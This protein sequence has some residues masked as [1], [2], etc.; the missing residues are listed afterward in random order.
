[1]LVIMATPT[2]RE[3]SPH[4]LGG[5]TIPSAAALA[6][7]VASFRRTANHSD[8]SGLTRRLTD[9]GNDEEQ[10]QLKLLGEL[11][12]EMRRWNNG[13]LARGLRYRPIL[14]PPLG[15]DMMSNESNDNDRKTEE[16][17]EDGDASIDY[18]CAHGSHNNSQR[19]CNSNGESIEELDD[20]NEE[21]EGGTEVPGTN[22]SPMQ[23]HSRI[24]LKRQQSFDSSSCSDC[25]LSNDSFVINNSKSEESER[26]LLNVTSEL[27]NRGSDEYY[28][29]T[30]VP[31]TQQPYKRNEDCYEPKRVTP[32]ILR[33]EVGISKFQEVKDDVPIDDHSTMKRRRVQDDEP[34]HW[35]RKRQGAITPIGQT[36]SNVNDDPDMSQ[37]T[38]DVGTHDLARIDFLSNTPRRKST[39][40]PSQ[41]SS[42]LTYAI[43]TQDIK[44]IDSWIR[45]S[46]PRP[47]P[48]PPPLKQGI[49]SAETTYLYIAYDVLDQFETRALEFLHNQG[50][51]RIVLDEIREVTIPGRG[52]VPF[53]A[54][55][56]THGIVEKPIEGM[57]TCY[58]SY[59]YL[60][61]VALGALAVDA[62][63]LVES[64]DA[65]ILQDCNMYKIGRDVETH[66]R[67]KAPNI[68]TDDLTT[69]SSRRSTITLSH[70]FDG[71]VLGLL[72]DID[73]DPRAHIHETHAD[74][75]L[76]N[77][78]QLEARQITMQEI[79]SLVKCLGGK[80]CT[81][82]LTLSN[83]LLINDWSTLN[84][85]MKA[86]HSNLKRSNVSRW[87]V[88][89][90]EPGELDEFIVNG[91][92]IG[93]NNVGGVQ[94][95]ARI[96]I[97]R[98]K[99]LED[100]ICLTS[101]QCLDSYCWGILDERL[102]YCKVTCHSSYPIT[103]LIIIY[104]TKYLIKV[105]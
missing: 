9:G 93:D 105:S 72:R 4:I 12:D 47:P 62:R 38:Y 32:H 37:L 20:D 53:P 80:V 40:P 68:S 55:L 61:A 59:S 34:V 87:L 74:I 10:P 5:A 50:L 71:M 28:V 96:P 25:E 45:N 33:R 83:V 98:F 76:N 60:K 64:M 103:I 101:L 42:Q 92:L 90:Y 54:I 17:D 23:C 2:P 85:I 51:V 43:E 75:R 95:H 48:P 39:S 63:W 21:E 58:R 30:E 77:Q 15:N 91:R 56:V 97:I 24:N 11:L 13:P 18:T 49:Q 78:L 70:T 94:S 6:E 36:C 69:S 99:W 35:T 3:S 89:K 79:E 31:G 46:C 57:T 41:Q 44:R 29:E 82:S 14:P 73:N 102:Y 104:Q 66:S 100:S 1:V 19:G 27:D 16:D 81:D 88:R 84:Q 67:L 65:G 26:L 86:L 8:D 52:V 7:I 22:L